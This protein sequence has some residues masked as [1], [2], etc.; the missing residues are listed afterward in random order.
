MYTFIYMCSDD[1]MYSV[2]KSTQHAHLVFA[3]A[4]YLICAGMFVVHVFFKKK[5]CFKRIHCMNYMYSA[6]TYRQSGTVI[7]MVS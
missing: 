3:G 1:Y 7:T 2:G 5:K 4:V 6:A